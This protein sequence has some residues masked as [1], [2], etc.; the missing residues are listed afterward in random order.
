MKSKLLF[1][2]ALMSAASLASQET[3]EAKGIV[4]DKS[5][6]EY[7]M[8]ELLAEVKDGQVDVSGWVMRNA[9]MSI[10]SAGMY[11][12]QIGWKTDVTGGNFRIR[13]SGAPRPSVC[14]R[15]PQLYQYFS[16][17]CCYGQL[18]PSQASD[19]RQGQC[20]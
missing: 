4:T 13:A 16:K 2:A 5:A 15:R 3:Y 7:A 9:K 1:T 10:L 19:Y 11:D 18:R 14:G 12:G 20:R 17:V 8:G 6:Y